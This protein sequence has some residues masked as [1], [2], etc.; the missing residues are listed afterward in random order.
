M[1]EFLYISR[2][3]GCIHMLVCARACHSACVRYRSVKI[4]MCK[5]TY[6]NVCLFS[7][8]QIS[9]YWF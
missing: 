7:R 4:T 9:V 3:L 5:D 2:H 6:T 8:P 1:R